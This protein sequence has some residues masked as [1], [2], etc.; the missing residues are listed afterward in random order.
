MVNTGHDIFTDY[1][2][3]IVSIRS[4]M[5]VPESNDVT[6]LVDDDTELIAIL[7]DG[8]GLRSITPFANK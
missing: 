4:G 6:Q 2:N 7:A 3:M 5:F 1:V 8:N